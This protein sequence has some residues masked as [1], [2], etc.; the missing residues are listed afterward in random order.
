MSPPSRSTLEWAGSGPEDQDL[1]VADDV[2]PASAE[3]P[4]RRCEGEV[5][6]AQRHARHPADDR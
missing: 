2:A 3:E 4:S 1:R 5:E 6:E